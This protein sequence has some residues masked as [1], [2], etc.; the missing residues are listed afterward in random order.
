MSFTR[1]SL[2]SALCR[3]ISALKLMLAP[4][5]VLGTAGAHS[6]AHT[7]TV[8]IPGQTQFTATTVF[9][10]GS[11]FDVSQNRLFA[12]VR[13]NC[14][15]GTQS[16]F[17]WADTKTG[18]FTALSVFDE[19]FPSFTS[20]AILLDSRGDYA[21]VIGAGLKV[22]LH[23]GA[24]SPTAI[25]GCC[26]VIGMD[27]QINAFYLVDG[28]T[29]DSQ[30]DVLN[31]LTG[32]AITLLALNNDP[33]S[34]LDAVDQNHHVYMTQGYDNTKQQCYIVK[35]NE[36]G[37]E[38]SYFYLPRHS[39]GSGCLYGMAYDNTRDI[40]YA[41]LE[42]FNDINS[43]PYLV[44]INLATT[45][46][47]GIADIRISRQTSAPAAIDPNNRM[48]AFTLP[49]G[50]TPP[51]IASVDTT[52]NRSWYINVMGGET[53]MAI[54]AWMYNAGLAAGMRASQEPKSAINISVLAF[55][56]PKSKV[57]SGETVYG[58]TGFS[59]RF[60][61]ASPVTQNKKCITTGEQC[62]ADIQTA[63]EFYSDG[64]WDGLL[65]NA[66]AQFIIVVG[67]SNDTLQGNTGSIDRCPSGGAGNVTAAH[68]NAWSG[69]VQSLRSYLQ[70]EGH[71]LQISAFGGID[72]E[73]DWSSPDKVENWE[74]GY[75]DRAGLIDFGNAE[76]APL[77]CPTDWPT[78][79][80]LTVA[81]PTVIPQIYGIGGGNARTWA[82]LAAYGTM[83]ILAPLTQWKA[84]SQQTCHK[85]TNNTPY[86]AWDQLRRRLKKPL[87]PATDIEHRTQ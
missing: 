76:G 63:V 12:L 18:V 57:I 17:G 20:N 11:A 49:Q 22:D 5:L 6:S 82:D 70:N 8:V 31:P 56:A 69:M 28:L 67:T 37:G 47:V 85:G 61:P 29:S 41:L 27:P 21:Y 3:L 77:S 23:T 9:P 45:D 60:L 73:L 25:P 86:G 39:Y 24:T 78:E 83:T 72:A 16:T 7:K 43:D 79:D 65:G 48:L 26:S 2:E 54:N 1:T 64:V 46:I 53:Q 40:L 62:Y 52:P 4:V 71:D 32:N 58:A 13:E 87:G 33:S 44:A 36:T 42:G 59:R 66:S 50:S 74:A 51:Q 75:N 80:I 68:G 19:P 81:G 15:A 35:L 38:P 14:Y 34:A 10:C 55:G 84:C 30:V